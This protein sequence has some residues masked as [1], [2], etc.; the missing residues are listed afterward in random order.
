MWIENAPDIV[1]KFVADYTK[2]FKSNHIAT[3]NLTDV[4]LRQIVMDSD[5]AE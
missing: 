4:E 2:R 1:D 5:N 3:R